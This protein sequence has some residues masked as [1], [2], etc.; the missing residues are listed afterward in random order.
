[1]SYGTF[2]LSNA[3]SCFT[4]CSE[5]IRGQS[6][7]QV[8]K[9]PKNVKNRWLLGPRIFRGRGYRNFGH[10]LTSK[11]VAGFGWVSFSELRG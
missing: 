9:S 7:R 6:R 4:T 3:T 1:M 11:H 8:A 2:V 10:A 5:D